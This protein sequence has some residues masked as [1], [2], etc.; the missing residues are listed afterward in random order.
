MVYQRRLIR[1]TQNIKQSERRV[2]DLK[3]K[4]TVEEKRAYDTAWRLKNLEKCRQKDRESYQRRK[5]KLSALHKTP[6]FRAGQREYQRE[7]Y[8]THKEQMRA[9]RRKSYYAN[10]EHEKA[11]SVEY[12][13]SGRARRNRLKYA[14]NLTPADID[15]RCTAQ[16]GK[17]AICGLVAPLQLDHNHA[18]GETRDMLCGPCNRAYGLLNE[19]ETTIQGALNYQKKW[20]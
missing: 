6:E 7:Y 12:R 15:A 2:H 16:G 9:K 3:H 10:I 14:Y 13:A 17:C 11:Y 18:T 1:H 20:K 19:C 8:A 4:K 5:A